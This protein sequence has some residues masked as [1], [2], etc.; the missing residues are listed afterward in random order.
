[1]TMSMDPIRQTENYEFKLRLGATGRLT[2]S[3]IAERVRRYA[4]A[5]TQE[6][7]VL[8]GV[9]QVLCELGVPTIM[10]PMYHAYSRQLGKLQ[11]ADL[12]TGSR[13][14]ELTQIVG[15]WVMRGLS[16]RALVNIAENVFNLPLPAALEEEPN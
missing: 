6:H 12:S 14:V 2:E 15:T 11:R 10:F 9:R 7:Q 5:A 8:M 16:Q 3:E 1:M 13:D 4:V